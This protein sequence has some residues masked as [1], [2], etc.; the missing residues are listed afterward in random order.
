MLRIYFLIIFFGLMTFFACSQKKQTVDAIYLNATIYTVDSIFSVAE[1]FAVNDGKFVAVGSRAEIELNFFSENIVDLQ[2]KTVF[3]GFYDSHCHFLGYG[4][5]LQ[6]ANLKNCTSFQDVLKCLVEH[7]NSNGGEWIL[8]RGWDQ[9]NWDIKQLPNNKLLDSLFPD[10]PVIITRIDGHAVVAN[11]LALHIARI[12]AASVVEGGEVV[13]KDGKPTGLLLDKAADLMKSY[14][15]MPDDEMLENFLLSAQSDCFKV[16]LTSVADAGLGQREIEIIEKLHSSNKLKMRMYVMLNDDSATLNYFVPKGIIANER[17]TVRCIK[18]YA[19]GA[20]GSRGAALIEPYSD[21]TENFGLFVITEKHFEDVCKMALSNGFQVATHAIGDA[22]NR[23]VL[24]NYAKFL[25]ENNN[26][27]WRLEHAQVVH[28]NDFTFFE[29]YNIIPSVQTTHATSDMF[30][31]DERLGEERLK[32]AYAYKTLL[33][34]NG[35][36]SN[37]SDFPI[38]D[39]NPLYGFYAAVARKNHEELPAGGF[40]PENA[41]S[42]EE[43]L[44]ATTIWAA[45]VAFEENQKGSI[46]VGKV[47]DFVVLEKDIMKIPENEIFSTKVLKTFINGEMVFQ[48]ND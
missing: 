43:A 11:S 27:R 19:D 12:E 29:R 37:G 13:V 20:L 40:Q 30:W 3:P 33:L 8:G 31:A 10:N 16:G 32:N 34:Q 42:R 9:N 1:A 45:K 24:Q 14:I 36:L 5:T 38:E 4:Q 15:P 21:D 28:S 7:H 2:Q 18:L 39:I 22:A 48:L 44:R 35:W 6:Y 41:L 17:L 23:F 46:E 47:A 25:P 26:L